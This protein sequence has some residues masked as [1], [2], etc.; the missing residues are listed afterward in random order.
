VRI[1]KFIALF[2]ISAPLV[3]AG[4]QSTKEM[5]FFEKLDHMI[6]PTERSQWDA[7]VSR[8]G[9][10]NLAKGYY[11]FA[12]GACNM[13]RQGAHESAVVENYSEF[14][15]KLARPLVAAAKKVI[16]PELISK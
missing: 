11:Q 13:M 8:E 7:Y 4:Q 3:V 2:V 6:E 16:C 12:V 5:E 9:A 15:G 14:H 10:D 1:S